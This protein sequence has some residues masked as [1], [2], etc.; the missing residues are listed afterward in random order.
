MQSNKFAICESLERAQQHTRSSSQWWVA[1]AVTAER[2]RRVNL[3]ARPERWRRSL[4][5]PAESFPPW[6]CC[7]R[8][9]KMSYCR[10]FEDITSNQRLEGF[11]SLLSLLR[12]FLWVITDQVNHPDI[13]EKSN[14]AESQLIQKVQN[15]S[16]SRWWR[17]TVS[18]FCW[19]YVETTSFDWNII[20][21]CTTDMSLIS[22]SS[23]MRSTSSFRMATLANSFS[24]A[25]F[26]A[27][28]A[29]C[30]APAKNGEKAMLRSWRPY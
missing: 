23:A 2:G 10:T 11:S 12:N 15:W 25:N 8:M 22:I 28:F 17:R 3:S 13:R 18:P 16:G 9:K 24:R 6:F 29:I 21:V 20:W 5:A 14:I 1:F 30:R 19:D 27:V 26:S 4:R 7:Q